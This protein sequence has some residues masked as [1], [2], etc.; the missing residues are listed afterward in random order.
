MIRAYCVF[1]LLFAIGGTSMA[2]DATRETWALAIHGGAG[3]VERGS[4]STGAYAGFACVDS[5]SACTTSSRCSV[6]R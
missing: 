2:Q 4:L 6:T 3:T 5:R 1:V